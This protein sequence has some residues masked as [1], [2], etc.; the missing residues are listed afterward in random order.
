M[1]LFQILIGN[2]NTV[3]TL[4]TEYMQKRLMPL[5]FLIHLKVR[6]LEHHPADPVRR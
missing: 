6:T 2:L 3:V 1:I 4:D 5:V